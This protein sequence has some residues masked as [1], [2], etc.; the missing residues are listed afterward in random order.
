M[1]ILIIKQVIRVTLAGVPLESGDP[2]RTV[3]HFHIA[4]H[5]VTGE[6]Y[7]GLR[8][9]IKNSFLCF[10]RKGGREII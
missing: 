6:D 1:R 3:W 4:R 10:Q 7:F 8:L 5:I 2:E 9:I